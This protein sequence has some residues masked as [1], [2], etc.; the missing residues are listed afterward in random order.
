MKNKLIRMLLSLLGFASS[1][2]CETQEDA[3]GCPYA[4]FSVKGKVTDEAGSPIPGIAVRVEYDNE[5]ATDD[6]GTFAFD[7][8]QW[9]FAPTSPVSIRFSDIDGS[10]NGSFADQE[11]EVTFARNSAVASDGWYEGHFDADDIEVVLQEKAEE[12]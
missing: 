10:E 1:C 8:A 2:A 4:T 7:R 6:T 3:Y 12:Q 5:T 9:S 11:V